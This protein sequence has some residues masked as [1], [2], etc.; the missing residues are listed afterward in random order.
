VAQAESKVGKYEETNQE[1]ANSAEGNKGEVKEERHQEMTSKKWD[2]PAY[3]RMVNVGIKGKEL[4]VEFGTGEVV[5]V[6]AEKVVPPG[7]HDINWHSLQ[8]DDYE[9]LLSSPSG[10]F[11]IPWLTIRLVTDADFAAFWA[12][13]AEESASQV[14][15]RLRQLRKRRG[16]SSKEVAERAGITPQSLSRIERGHHDVVYTT[17][18]KILAAMGCTLRDLAEFQ[19]ETTSLKDVLRHLEVVGLKKE[20]VLSR[21]LSEDMRN[22]F[23]SGR[24]TDESS[25]VRHLAENLSRVYS[26]PKDAIVGLQQIRIDASA[27]AGARFKSQV[28]TNEFQAQ[29]YAVFAHYLALLALSA[30]P[31]IKASRLPEDPAELRDRV[32]KHYQALTLENLLQTMWDMGIPVIP[33]RDPG[34]FHGACWKTSGRHVIVLKQLAQFHARWLF[35]LAHEGGHAARHL[36]NGQIGYIE[37]TEISPFD[38]SPDEQE[39][40]EF[41]SELLLFGR[42]EELTEKCVEVA[43][44]HLQYLK[45]AVIQVAASERVAVDVLANYVAHRLSMQGQNWWATANSLQVDDPAAADVVT[46]ILFER[47][48]LSLLEEVDRDLFV[49]A[50][51]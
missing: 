23:A 14:G 35:D 50:V 24:R 21:F 36:S 5:E 31:H 7:I 9:I 44:G 47:I 2:E 19:G 39:A 29:A 40:S 1:E 30:T 17:L 13:K 10:Q 20:W 48:D 25:L 38:A 45:R 27:L 4:V 34:A 12:R 51:G 6:A 46:R 3:Q 22:A 41:A 15:S 26:W 8:H 33:L 37:P 49:R 32:I 16:L 28:R 43:Q 42:A 18:E 11:E